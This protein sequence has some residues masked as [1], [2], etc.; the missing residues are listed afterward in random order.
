MAPANDSNRLTMRPIGENYAIQLDK[1]F[2]PG[3]DEEGAAPN[4]VGVDLNIDEEIAATRPTPSIDDPH[5]PIWLSEPS[6]SDPGTVRSAE[7]LVRSQDLEAQRFS[8]SLLG[9]ILLGIAGSL[10]ANAIDV[11]LFPHPDKTRI[12]GQ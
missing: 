4:A 3:C 8:L 11:W 7:I 6:G 9:G 12:I 5:N 2:P 1:W 10:A